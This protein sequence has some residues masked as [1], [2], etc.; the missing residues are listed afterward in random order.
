MSNDIF[1]QIISMSITVMLAMAL[2]IIY[3]R[4]NI[5]LRNKKV[6][7]EIRRENRK[8][9]KNIDKTIKIS[10]IKIFAFLSV[11]ITCIIDLYV[12]KLIK[13]SECS[14]NFIGYSVQGGI[15]VLIGMVVFSYIMKFIIKNQ[16]IIFQSETDSSS[17]SDLL[18]DEYSSIKRFQEMITYAYKF[19]IVIIIIMFVIVGRIDSA[20]NW[21]IVLAGK[22]IWFGVFDIVTPKQKGDKNVYKFTYNDGIIYIILALCTIPFLL[23]LQYEI[24]LIDNIYY[25]I[26]YGLEIVA[27]VILITWSLSLVKK[28][29]FNS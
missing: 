4:R 21:G 13:N 20:I 1:V 17:S 22:Y 16:K 26:A 3:Q 12:K 29:F 11:L 7:N 18:N 28:R 5:E 27:G 8:E 14:N 9:V 24:S 10:C 25:G 6:S 2:G 19:A 23:S 15:I